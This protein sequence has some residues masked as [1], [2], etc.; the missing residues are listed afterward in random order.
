METI[1]NDEICQQNKFNPLGLGFLLKYIII[2]VLISICCF[3]IYLKYASNFF[4]LGT[5]LGNTPHYVQKR[6]L[7]EQLND[8]NNNN[9]DNNDN[10]KN[11][12]EKR[13]DNTEV[14]IPEYLKEVMNKLKEKDPNTLDIEFVKELEMNTKLESEIAKMKI[15]IITLHE[16]LKKNNSNNIKT[17]NTLI[18]NLNK[19]NNILLKKTNEFDTYVK[20]TQSINE[21]MIQDIQCLKKKGKTNKSKNDNTFSP[22]EPVNHGLPHVYAP[23]NKSLE[24]TFEN[25]NPR[26]I[27]T[28]AEGPDV[29]YPI[30]TI[31]ETSTE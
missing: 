17:Q 21:K 1:N 9:T 27:N 12:I 29:S 3:V 10:N 25:E 28:R 30:E 23:T 14:E 11:H 4:S 22:L 5:K 7:K 20:Q 26:V 13:K 8:L 24:N 15:D 6:S 31:H 2:I 18:E 19:S 16:E